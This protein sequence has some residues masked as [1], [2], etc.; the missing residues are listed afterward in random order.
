MKKIMILEEGEIRSMDIKEIIVEIENVVKRC[1]TEHD[2][3]ATAGHKLL[4]INKVAKR[5]SRGHTTIKKL[6]AHGVLKST[7]D[8]KVTE[9]ALAEYLNNTG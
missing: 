5:L 4:T 6:I 1:L 8:G 3:K 2:G 7:Q 9:A